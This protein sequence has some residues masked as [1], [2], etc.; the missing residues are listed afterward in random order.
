[1]TIANRLQQY[2]DGAGIGYDTVAHPRTMTAARS[3]EAA[4][5]PG[6]QVAK[7][8]LVHWEDGYFLAVVPSS[9][10]VEL[11]TLQDIADR[12]LGLATEDEIA[13]V[14]DDCELG[15]VPPVGAA[16]GVPVF[17]DASLDAAPDLYFEGGDH[18]TLVH[19][20]GE[21]FRALMKDARRARFSHPA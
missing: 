11:D 15:A 5:V 16:Y 19:V 10:R 18:T 21:A 8:V 4:H 17:L 7:S 12:R 3:A 13:R 9:H 14:F 2:L 20:S 6:S 1:M